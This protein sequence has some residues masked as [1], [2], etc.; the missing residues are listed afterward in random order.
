M[1][2][3]VE[4]RTRK[5][6]TRVE[7]PEYIAREIFIITQRTKTPLA[8]TVLKLTIA[9]LEATSIHAKEQTS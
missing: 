5:Y 1:N 2:I 4:N 6:K 8:E 7:V 9:Q 3:V